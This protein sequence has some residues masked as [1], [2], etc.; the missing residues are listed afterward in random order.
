M[1]NTTIPNLIVVGAGKAGTT[2]LHN[3]LDAHPQVFGAGDKNVGP[4]IEW[5]ASSTESGSRLSSQLSPAQP[6][7]GES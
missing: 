6:I 7:G 2:S 5:L 3:Y 4:R 1:Q